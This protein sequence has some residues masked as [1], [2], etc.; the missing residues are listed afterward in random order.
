MQ[1]AHDLTDDP[2][3]LDVTA[4]RAQ[5]HLVHLE[6]DASLH[7]LEAVARVRKGAG[8]DDGVGVLQERGAHLAVDV[9]VDDAVTRLALARHLDASR[10]DQPTT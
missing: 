6:D 7:G 10:A 1:P 3:A 4:V 5:P 2:G 8:V 9:D